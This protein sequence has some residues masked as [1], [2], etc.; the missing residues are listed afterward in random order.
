MGHIWYIVPHASS[1]MYYTQT[2]F[3][4]TFKRISPAAATV[5]PAL[6]VSD[7]GS[8]AEC[9]P[10][11]VCKLADLEEWGNAPSAGCRS[12]VQ[13]LQWRI[14]STGMGWVCRL[15]EA[16][17]MGRG[18][19]LG[20]SR[21]IGWVCRLVK[22]IPKSGNPDHR[23]PRTIFDPKTPTGIFYSI[24]DF[25]IGVFLSDFGKLF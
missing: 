19:R 13:S 25:G 4:K 11:T 14:W 18:C 5:S 15:G 12:I 3:S 10:M 22:S 17:G 21:G 9:W 2:N 1:I 20:E 6:V 16:R 24:P 7:V 23:G 8:S